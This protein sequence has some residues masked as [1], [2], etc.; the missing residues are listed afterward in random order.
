M[1]QTTEIIQEGPVYKSE[2]DVFNRFWQYFIVEQHPQAVI[3]TDGFPHCVYRTPDGNGCGIG[4]LVDD[5]TAEK[6]DR[7]SPNVSYVGI[8]RK[9]P[10][11]HKKYFSDS[12]KI[13]FL[14]ALQSL[15]DREDRNWY[16]EDIF[17]Q[18]VAEDFARQHNLMV[19][20]RKE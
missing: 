9:F 3:D 8:A 1:G 2:Q 18:D 12:I 5:K 6:W 19:P 11:D 17:R 10:E 20:E 7:E 15:H 16:N 13:E 4:C 14:Q